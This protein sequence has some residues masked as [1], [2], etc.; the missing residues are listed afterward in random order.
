M[1]VCL[2]PDL[3]G[4]PIVSSLP[5]SDDPRQ[6]QSPQR[7]WSPYC[8]WHALAAS[9]PLTAEVP[10]VCPRR[11]SVSETPALCRPACH[12]LLRSPPDQD[13]MPRESLDGPSP[14]GRLLPERPADCSKQAGRV[15]P[16]ASV[17]MPDYAFPSATSTLSG[18]NGTERSRTPMAS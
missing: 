6:V 16:P 15:T 14:V 13:R 11:S 7:L 12:S 10:S 2:G 9:V 5:W 4:R 3:S 1:A 8:T 17:R 18:V